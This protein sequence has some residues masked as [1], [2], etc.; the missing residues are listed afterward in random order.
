MQK[1]HRQWATENPTDRRR[2]LYSLLGK[3]VWLRAAPRSVH[4]HQGR[5]TAGR[6]GEAMRACNRHLAGNLETLRQQ[7]KA[8]TFEPLP[9][10]RVDMPTANGKP[11]P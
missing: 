3:A 1:K 5:A 4:T 11:R 7:L 10:R 6:D 2:D 8:K 9:G